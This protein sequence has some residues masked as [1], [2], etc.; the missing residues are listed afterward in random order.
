MG[1][2]PRN[3]I[4]AGNKLTQSLFLQRVG[5]VQDYHVV[6][7]KVKDERKRKKEKWSRTHDLLIIKCV[8]YHCAVTIDG[9]AARFGIALDLQTF[10]T[11][12]GL[13]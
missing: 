1:S 12:L 10:T 8:F 4:D 6:M 3:A 2:L 13:A 9:L 5:N 11:F 7:L